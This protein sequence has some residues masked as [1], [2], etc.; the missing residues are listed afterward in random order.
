[1][2]EDTAKEL[3]RWIN[4]LIVEQPLVVVEGMNDKKALEH[5]GFSN[6]I[7][8]NKP[9]YAIVEDVARQTK[10]AVILT[11]LDSK[12]KEIYGK[13]SKDLQKHGVHIDDGFRRF[14]FKNTPLREIEGLATF[15]ETIH[16]KH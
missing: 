8:L 14:L 7:T 9:L 10:K 12:G 1:M 3:I 5:L 16:P 2:L 11:D 15:V 13:L 4:K 6:I